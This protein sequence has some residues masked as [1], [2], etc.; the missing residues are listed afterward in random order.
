MINVTINEDETL[1][2]EGVIEVG[3]K[4]NGLC[5]DGF[6]CEVVLIFPDPDPIYVSVWY[7]CESPSHDE[8]RKLDMYAAVGSMLVENIADF[9]VS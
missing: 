3:E 7:I 6:D 4:I 1:G 5:C 9:L 8:D 2:I